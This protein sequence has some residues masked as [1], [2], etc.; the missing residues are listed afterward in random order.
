[1]A[2]DYPALRVL[3]Y[4]NGSRDMESKTLGIWARDRFAHRMEIVVETAPTNTGFAGG[5]NRAIALA[6]NL[7]PPFRYVFLV[8][9]DAIVDRRCIGELVRVAEENRAMLVSASILN[10]DGSAT[11]FAYDGPRWPLFFRPPRQGMPDGA[12]IAW[13]SETA[14]GAALLIHERVVAELS[15]ERGA[16][17]REDLFMYFEDTELAM[18]VR[19]RGWPVYVARNAHVRHHVGGSQSVAA[20]HR[21]HYYFNRNRIKVA[22]SILPF[23]GLLLFHAA[24]APLVVARVVRQLVRGRGDVARAMW[25]GFIDG[26]GGK[27]GIWSGHDGLRSRV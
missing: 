12:S 24:N 8:N 18:N 23:L 16:T 6:E 3:L 17:F 9:N 27:S 4:D 26:M 11:E 5:C 25:Q 10:Q 21:F 15:R 13:P 7:D 14:C 2:S 19:Q 22:R 1:M 20:E